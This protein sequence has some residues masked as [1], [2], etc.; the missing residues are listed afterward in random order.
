MNKGRSRPEQQK[1]KQTHGP[2]KKK[3]HGS[4]GS[5][6]NNGNSNRSA[7]H[8]KPHNERTQLKDNAKE[9]QKAYT[10]DEAIE[11]LPFLIKHIA[12]AG[13]NKIKSMLAHGQ[14]AV[15]GKPNTAYNFP[16]RPGS[17]V[18]LNKGRAIEAPP[19]EGMKIVHEDDDVIVIVKQAGLLSVSS[20]TGA[21]NEV[22]AY[23]QL[24]AYVRVYNPNNRI[25]IVH[26]LDR[27]TSGLM[28]FARSE[29]IQQQLQNNWQETVQE[30]MYVALVEGTVK[31]PQGT[32]SSWLKESKTLKMYSSSYPN[33][34]QHAVTHYK[35]LRSDRNF[36]LLEVH[37]ETGR[38]NQ[39]RVHMEEI[40]H[41]VVGDKKYGAR[42]KAIG[43]LGLH[44]RVLA[45]NH[46]ATG[47]L[48]RFETEIPKLFL[49]PFQT[50]TP[51]TK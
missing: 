37:L 7:G 47:K 46:P 28:L 2:I 45:F 19:L 21:E 15:D 43:R 35:V 41:P 42:T 10:V 31:Q 34:G 51:G 4:G 25:F 36:S 6:G 9:K 22:T 3:N 32:I 29:A 17:T 48:L 1:Q 23:R 5:N 49:K 26:R 13:R 14:I 33:D 27:D 50:E 30:R 39:I 24:M 18:T 40:G 12:G 20:T 38:K 8:I 11:L 16:L 44:A